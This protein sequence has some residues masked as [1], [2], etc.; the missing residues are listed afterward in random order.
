MKDESIN[1]LEDKLK[2][3]KEKLTRDMK[4]M[5]IELDDTY[6]KLLNKEKESN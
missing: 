6:L 1:R 5:E 2:K 3:E 4:D